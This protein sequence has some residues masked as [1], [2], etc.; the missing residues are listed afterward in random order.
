MNITRSLRSGPCYFLPAGETW[1]TAADDTWATSATVADTFHV[2]R[3]IGGRI[4]NGTVCRV[5]ALPSG[6]HVAQKAS[7]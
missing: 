6:N 2:A 3:L 4:I 7:F 1:K 5:F